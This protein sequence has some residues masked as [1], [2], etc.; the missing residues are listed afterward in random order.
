MGNKR[1]N[2]DLSQAGAARLPRLN[3]LE[4]HRFFSYENA[5]VFKAK[6]KAWHDNKNKKKEFTVGEQVL[7]FNPILKLFPEKLKSRC[8][9]P[10]KLIQIYPYEAVD[11]L[12]EASGHEFKVN[13]QRIKHYWGEP[14]ERIK[15]TTKMVD[16]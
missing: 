6:T 15:A 9:S 4:E 10:F 13:G 1:F 8:S 14:F 7:L 3:E 12:D 5:E 11:L 2:C 16:P